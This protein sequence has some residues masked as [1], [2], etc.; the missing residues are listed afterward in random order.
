MATFGDIIDMTRVLLGRPSTDTLSNG[1]LFDLVRSEAIFYAVE[2]GLTNVNWLWSDCYLSVDTN[3]NEYVI[4]AADFGRPIKVEYFD[5]T[6]PARNGP[7]IQI[8]DIQD[9][10]LYGGRNTSFSFQSGTSDVSGSDGSIIAHAIAFWGLPPNR[11]CRIV[12][13]PLEACQYRIMYEP[14]VSQTPQKL[15]DT[16]FLLT[17][18]EGLIA[19][20]AALAAVGRLPFNEFQMAAM[21]QNLTSRQ[22]RFATQFDMYR[23]QNKHSQTTLKRAFRPRGGS[24]RWTA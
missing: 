21:V 3:N 6:N 5:P 16:P 23:R 20:S 13:R 2:L 17:Q 8:I 11:K 10:D 24:G 15:T 9:S 7:E 18:F 14:L 22:S 19:T 1:D 12:P 4:S